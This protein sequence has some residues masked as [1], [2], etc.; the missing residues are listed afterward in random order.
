MAAR[1]SKDVLMREQIYASALET[2]MVVSQKSRNLSTSRTSYTI[3]GHLP[4]V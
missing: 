3:L 4:E 2:S 1:A